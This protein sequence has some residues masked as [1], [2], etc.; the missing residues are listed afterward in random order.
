MVMML[1][2]VLIVIVM[3]VTTAIGIVT[4]VLVVVV[5][6]VMMLVFVLIV[7]V[8]V[9][10]A[11]VGIVT[12]V[13]VVV[14]MMVMMLRRL[15]QTRQLLLNGV[16]TLHGSQELCAVQLLPRRGHD[17]CG[18]I[19]RTQQCHGIRDLF[20]AHALCVRE[21]DASRI[22]DLVV[23]KLAKVLHI[24][25]ALFHVCHGGKAVQNHILG[26]NA[27]YRADNIRELAHTRGLDQNTVGMI[28]VKHLTESFAKVPHERTADATAVHF[29]DLNARILHKAAVNADLAK[30][31]FDQYQLLTCIRFF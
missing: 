9:V 18:L 28:F 19:V 20:L 27:L 5:M 24:H 21:N 17:R 14:V 1:V 13:L 3:M 22:F 26:R 29:G 30:L 16:A 6:M 31:V 7:I 8:M 4:L 23:E 15:C 12:L 2:F 11:A 10:T 25:L